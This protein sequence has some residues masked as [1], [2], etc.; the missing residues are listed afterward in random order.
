MTNT[1]W[2]TAFTVSVVAYRLFSYCW[3]LVGGDQAH[4]FPLLMQR[5]SGLCLG[6]M[7]LTALPWERWRALLSIRP[8][9]A[10]WPWVPTLKTNFLDSVNPH[11]YYPRV[12]TASACHVSWHSLKFISLSAVVIMIQ[13]AKGALHVQL[14]RHSH[15]LSPVQQQNL[16][17]TSAT[18]EKVPGH[19]WRSDSLEI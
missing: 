4:V 11:I 9:L 8:L 3:R 18:I 15:I 5:W 17:L 14:Q 1:V 16:F 19:A 2:F 13:E 7:A 10:R 6:Y 12:T